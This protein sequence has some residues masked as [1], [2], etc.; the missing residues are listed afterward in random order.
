VNVIRCDVIVHCAVYLYVVGIDVAHALV[1]SSLVRR[2]SR[3]ASLGVTRKTL[4]VYRPVRSGRRTQLPDPS[5]LSLTPSSA[6]EEILRACEIDEGVAHE[7]IRAEPFRAAPVKNVT[8]PMT[9]RPSVCAT[10]PDQPVPQS[11]AR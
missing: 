11:C 3:R 1:R 5:P 10:Q 6:H 7:E 2:R 8:T 4:S 9:H